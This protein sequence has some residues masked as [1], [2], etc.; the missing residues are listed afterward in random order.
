MPRRHT[1]LRMPSE[2]GQCFCVS[3]VGDWGG[4]GL[5]DGEGVCVRGGR[6]CL[7]G[8]HLGE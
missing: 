3:G 7:K 8:G 4:R 1:L 2:V 5:G 6:G